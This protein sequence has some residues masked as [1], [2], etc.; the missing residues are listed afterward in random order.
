MSLQA[1]TPPENLGPMEQH[2]A[3]PAGEQVP[4]DQERRKLILRLKNGEPEEA[5][6]ALAERN[7]LDR[8]LRIQPQ[9]FDVL[10][11]LCRGDVPQTQDVTWHES[12]EILKKRRDVLDDGTVRPLVRNVMLSSYQMT[13]DGPVMT[14][15]FALTNQQD[16]ELADLIEHQVDEHQMTFVRDILSRLS[17]DNGPTR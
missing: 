7:I 4:D 3:R 5:R 2:R 8:L 12:L 11:R 10:L 9:V 14:Q 6:W 16:K 17:K 13:P 15:P 1:P